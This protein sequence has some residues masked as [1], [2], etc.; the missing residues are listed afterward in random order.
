MILKT[1]N[2]S[3]QSHEKNHSEKIKV[4]RENGEST[5]RDSGQSCIEVQ[6]IQLRP[7]TRETQNYLDIQSKKKLT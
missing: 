4:V 7:T 3:D 5:G 6:V 2:T 1:K